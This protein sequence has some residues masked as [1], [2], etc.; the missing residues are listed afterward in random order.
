MRKLL[1]GCVVCHKVEGKPFSPLPPPPLPEVRVKEQP[2]F[3]YTGVDFAGPLYLKDGSNLS[4]M[5]VISFKRFTARSG[6]PSKV[7]CDNG[8]TFKS[9]ARHIEEILKH[10]GVNRYFAELDMEREHPGRVVC[11]NR[12]IGQ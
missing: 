7:I 12:L 2:S 10:P 8:K 1:H 6:F 9:A 11:L 4:A 3:T 5:T